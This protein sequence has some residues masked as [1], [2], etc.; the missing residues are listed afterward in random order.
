MITATIPV[1]MATIE[2]GASTREQNTTTATRSRGLGHLARAIVAIAL[3]AL[4]LWQSDPR[5]VWQAARTADWRFIA[6]ACALV[7]IDRVLMAYRWWTLLAP[8]DRIGRPEGRHYESFKHDESFTHDE[9]VKHDE[10]ATH[11]QSAT[12]DERVHTVRS[13][14]LQVGGRPPVATVMRIFFVSSFVGTFL[15]ASVGGDAVRAYGLSKHGVA[16]VDAVASVLMDRL[17]GVISILIVAIGGALLARDLIDIRALF[18]ALAV[19]TLACSASLAVVFSPRAASAIAGALALLPRGQ[20]TAASL[21]TAIQRYAPLHLP[22]ANVLICSMG[23]QVLRVLQTYCLGLALGLAVPL[24]VYFALV[25]IILLIVLMPITINGIGTT[26]AGFVWLFG[27]AGVTSAPAFALS[28][29]FLG[30]AIVG[31]LP[32]GL[33]YLFGGKRA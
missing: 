28:V 24:G 16:G 14:D 9:S 1:Q 8:L 31:N 20:Q 11:D 19:L 6:L 21:V 32:G 2:T 33:L 29:L 4:L 7:V 30:I 5:A 3:T 10:S 25:P 13:A 12:H 26:Q 23:V 18:P 17:L 15:P 22:M 27:R